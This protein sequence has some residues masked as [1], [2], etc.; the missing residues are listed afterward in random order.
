MDQNKNDQERER[1][2][3]LISDTETS[4]DELKREQRKIE[5]SLQN[6]QTDLQRGYRQLA[7]LNEE[8]VRDGSVENLRM[9]RHDEVQEQEFKRELRQVEEHI[10]DSYTEQRKV[11]D[12]H[13]EEL[14]EKRSAV[15][16]D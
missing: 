9:Q 12:K 4:M 1:Y 13:K 16:W 5:E 14:Y 2:T 6:L 8:D 3:R 7:M 15:P 10:S 11:L